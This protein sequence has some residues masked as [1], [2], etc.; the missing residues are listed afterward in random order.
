M[1]WPISV[2]DLKD[3]WRRHTKTG[4][5]NGRTS[6]EPDALPE[7][8]STNEVAR[9]TSGTSVMDTARAAVRSVNLESTISAKLTPQVSNGSTVW[10]ENPIGYVETGSRKITDADLL[11]LGPCRVK[12]ERIAE[13][14]GETVEQTVAAIV[15]FFVNMDSPWL[16]APLGDLLQYYLDNFVL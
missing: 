12:L 1:A 9:S 11:S 13:G 16:G 3:R 15:T 6:T 8:A 10:M 4:S 5:V 2:A 14:R 7:T